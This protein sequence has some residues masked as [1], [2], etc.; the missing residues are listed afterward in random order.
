MKI[1]YLLKR[2]GILFGQTVFGIQVSGLYPEVWR[3]VGPCALVCV[4]C[5]LLLL[6]VCKGYGMFIAIH[7]LLSRES[8]HSKSTALLFIHAL[9]PGRPSSLAHMGTLGR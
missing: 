8:A 7:H 5:L 6:Q 4:A 2:Y 1:I 9:T 3:E